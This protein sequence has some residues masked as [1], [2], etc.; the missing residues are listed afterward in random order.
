M[1]EHAMRREELGIHHQEIQSFEPLR[2]VDYQYY[3]QYLKAATGLA[4]S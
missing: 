4:G 1:R 2:F 3:L